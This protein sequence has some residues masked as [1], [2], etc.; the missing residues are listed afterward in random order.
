MASYQ[1]SLLTRQV[2][3]LQQELVSLKA[4]QR[5]LTG[6]TRGYQS[7]L[8]RATSKV[9]FIVSGY[10]WREIYIELTV[11][12]DHA[13]KILTPTLRI[14]LYSSSGNPIPFGAGQWND[15]VGLLSAVDWAGDSPNEHKFSVLLYI[16][17]SQGT[18]DA[19]YG[20]FWAVAN[21]SSIINISATRTSR[22]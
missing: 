16:V 11:R 18:T 2:T 3:E 14:Q 7:N 22:N 8:V 21:D 4:P 19:F 5:Y 15:K 10:E 1:E 17:G 13:E 6:N 9:A 12:G 20:D